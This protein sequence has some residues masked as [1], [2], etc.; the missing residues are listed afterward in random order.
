MN[1]DPDQQPSFVHRKSSVV[2]SETVGAG[3]LSGAGAEI[4]CGSGF[5]QESYKKLGQ[6]NYLS[7]ASNI[8]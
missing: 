5:N 6:K 3:L 1:A 4:S 8:L 7:R 2:E